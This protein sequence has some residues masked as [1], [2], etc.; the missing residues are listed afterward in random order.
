MMDDLLLQEL[1][2]RIC[3]CPENSW[4]RG[5]LLNKLILDLSKDKKLLKTSHYDYLEALNLTWLWLCK[6]ICRIFANQKLN[7][8]TLLKIINSY[9]YWRIKDL[10]IP[11]KRLFSLEV[12]VIVSTDEVIALGNTFLT[13][14]VTGIDRHIERW[15]LQE[16]EKISLELEKYIEKDPQNKLQNTYIKNVP[17]CN[18]QFLSRQL[19]LKAPPEKVSNIARELYLSQSTIHSFWKRKCL[20]MLREIAIE[21]GYKSEL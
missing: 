6:N 7:R 21:L 2:K 9:L 1:I 3:Q 12:D 13:T 11:E 4:E 8:E 20:I 16:N 10:Y 14:N 15:Q 18:C 17:I 5:R 19:L